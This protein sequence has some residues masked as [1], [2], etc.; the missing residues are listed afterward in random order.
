[1]EENLTV[2]LT[3]KQ[4]TKNIEWLLENGSAPVKYLTHTKLLAETP[5]PKETR[6]LWQEV[7][8]SPCV[9]EIF[10]KQE[11]NGAWHAGGSWAHKPSY[12]LKG[13]VDP[14]TPKSVK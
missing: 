4:I 13:G 12:E 6:R 8:S 1:M 2:L 10:S 3:S 11:R 9:Q 5:S 7:E 14:Y